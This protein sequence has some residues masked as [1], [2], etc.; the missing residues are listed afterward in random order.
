M[1]RYQDQVIEAVEAVEILG[2]LRYAWLGTRSRATPAALRRELAA[3]EQRA[4]LLSFLAQQLYWS[5]YCRG[6]VVRA[7]WLAPEA[8]A[9]DAGLALAVASAGGSSRRW[10]PGWAVERVHDGEVVATRSG[11]RVRAPADACRADDGALAPGGAMSLPAGSPAI[12]PGYR[13]VVGDAG[14]EARAVVRVYWHVTCAGAAP[15][16]GALAAKLNGERMR[17]RLKVADHPSR[18]DRCDAAVLYV[19]HDTFFR[20]RTWLA[21]LALETAPR[22]RSR[23]PA[24]TLPFAP[25]VGLAEDAGADSFGQRR[26][27]LLADGVL[28]AHDRGAT[29]VGARV[30]AVIASF[31][32]AGV[33]IDA[34]YLEPSLAGRHVF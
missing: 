9:M 12:S 18:F 14:P 16:V 23:T 27:A 31:A 11:L 25:G 8:V 34:P 3:H 4:V 1:S 21:S 22:L 32:R 33:D 19:G 30:D 13:S 15:L 7:R 5:F 28:E 17:F 6:R 10:E 29:S 20:L 24:L 2:P 26:C